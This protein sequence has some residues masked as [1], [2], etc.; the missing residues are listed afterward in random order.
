MILKNRKFGVSKKGDEPKTGI[1]RRPVK[2]VQGSRMGE[3]ENRSIRIRSNIQPSI[4]KTQVQGLQGKLGENEDPPEEP[5]K[6]VKKLTFQ[7]KQKWPETVISIN[8]EEIISCMYCENGEHRTSNCPKMN[9]N[10]R[11]TEEHALAK[12]TEVKHIMSLAGFDLVSWK[13][14][15]SLVRSGFKGGMNEQKNIPENVQANKES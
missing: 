9:V 11:D 7:Q 12:A 3:Q 8:T 15:S 4:T 1:R 6:H 14:N 5:M 10:T 2:H 13:T